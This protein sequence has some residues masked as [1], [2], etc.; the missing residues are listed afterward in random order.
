MFVCLISLLILCVYWIF[1]FVGF[2]CGWCVM[3]LA[4]VCCLLMS[5]LIVLFCLLVWCGFTCLVVNCFGIC[6][7]GV[8][9]CALLVCW[10]V[11]L[12]V[13]IVLVRLLCW[14]LVTWVLRWFCISLACVVFILGFPFL[15]WMLVWFGAFVFDNS[16]VFVLYCFLCLEFWVWLYVCCLWCLLLVVDS[17]GCFAYVYFV[18]VL[19]D[20]LL[21]FVCVC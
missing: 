5:C 8:Y 9:Y 21:C 15:A 6:C 4:A 16:V 14:L 11:G 1:C 7:Y 12:P 18:F 17:M 10:I 2:Y 13:V 3:V 19:I 20:C